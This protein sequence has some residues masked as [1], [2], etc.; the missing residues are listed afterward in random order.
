MYKIFF[1]F[2][3]SFS[4]ENEKKTNPPPPLCP[5][6][7]GDS[8]AASPL[9]IWDVMPPYLKTLLKSKKQKFDNFDH[10]AQSDPLKAANNVSISQHIS[11]FFPAEKK[12]KLN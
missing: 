7:G 8:S 10:F 11:I 9:K 5:L 12:I 4:I 2:S 3:F 1:P 6:F